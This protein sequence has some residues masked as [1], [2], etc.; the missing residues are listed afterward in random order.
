M[1]RTEFIKKFSK[2]LKV[3]MHNKGYTSHRSKEK[4]E[5]TELANIAGC[6]YQMA[7]RYALG[8]ALP[9]MNILYK[10]ALHLDVSPGWL[11]FGEKEI[12]APDS[13][14]TPV[15]EIEKDILSYIL[16]KCTPFFYLEKQSNEIIVSYIM[17][18]VYDASH[19][20][21][22]KKTIL[23]IVDMMVNSTLKL[24]QA[25]QEVKVK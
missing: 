13:K 12:K 3:S 2:R 20:N 23:K 9:E 16:N 1:N 6:S 5:I 22:D 19:L 25:E 15:I 17:D 7:R 21:T 11:L 24:N 14:A 4:I 10:I 18:I 8:E